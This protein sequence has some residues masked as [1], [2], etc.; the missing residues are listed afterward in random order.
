MSQVIYN[1]LSNKKEL[2]TPL[3]GNRINAYVCGITAYDYS[4]IG[5][6]RSVVVFD[7]I[8]RYLRQRGFEVRFVRNFTDVDDKI[9]K[10]AQQEQSTCEAVSGKFIQEFRKDM[11]ALGALNPDQEPLATEYI[12]NMIETIRLLVEK[13]HAY[14]SQGSVYFSV[15]SFPGYGKLSGRDTDEL[16]TGVRIEV[17]EN[18]REPLDFALWKAAKP[19]EPHWSSPWGE[20]RPGWHIECS[21]MS[22]SILGPTLDIH[23]GGKDLIF[24][25][26]ENEIAQAEAATGKPFVRFWLHNG[27]INI[28]RQKMSKSLG[29]FLTVRDILKQFHPESVRLFLLSK[30]Y[31]SPLDYSDESLREVESSVERVYNTLKRI[32][33]ICVGVEPETPA[34]GNLST[35]A[36]EL[37][38]KSGTLSDRFAEAMDDDFNTAKATGLLFDLV[39]SMN[40]FLD[41]IAGAPTPEQAF[42]LKRSQAAMIETARTLG[43]FQ[44]GWNT[45][46]ESRT[47]KALE[48]EGV[49]VEEIE[50]LIQERTTARK[51]RDWAKADRIRHSLEGRGVLLEDTPEGTR[52]RTN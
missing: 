50:R 42:V 22:T 11:A 24:P 43:V 46:F 35:V 7:V 52:W 48:E 40:R 41:E 33:E 21:V 18:K 28:D 20:G 1:T 23:G 38:E 37:L 12:P 2:L 31:R 9:I 47:R 5:H 51:E 30:H 3:S 16:M 6:A 13:G 44:M 17:D 4:H 49:S 8:V 34:S 27:F 25:H 45:F 10:R 14:E 29:N 26:H 39:R 19:G 36:D 15:S 32:D